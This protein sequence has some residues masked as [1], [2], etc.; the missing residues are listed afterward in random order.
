VSR[1][2]AWALPPGF[3]SPEA[4]DTRIGT[5]A[6]SPEGGHDVLLARFSETS[7]SMLLDRLGQGGDLLAR[8]SVREIAMILGRVGARFLDP[9]DEL[10]REAEARLPGEAALGSTMARLVIEGMARD[11]SE[12]R[13]HRLLEEEFEDPEVLDGLRMSGTG[14]LLGATGGRLAYHLGAGNVPGVGTTSLVRSLLVK[15]PVVLKPGQ[16][17]MTLP[18]L[19]ARGLAEVDPQ[20]AEALAVVYWPR[21]HPDA[22][23]RQLV[24][25][26]DRVVAYGGSRMVAELRGRIPATT[27]LVAYHHRVSVG[28]V[29]REA[30]ANAPEARRIAAAAARAVTLFEGRGCVSPR[31]IWVESGGRI[32]P[33]EWATMLADSLVALADEWPAPTPHPSE[34]AGIRQIREAAEMRIA[35]GAPGKLIGDPGLA[36]TVL[37]E[38]AERRLEVSPGR[39]VQLHPIGSLEELPARLEPLASVLQTVALEAPGPR[40][41]AL[42]EALRR[43]GVSR[44]TTFG[45]QPWPPAWW[46]HDGSGPLRSLV[47]WTEVE[48]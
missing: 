16:G 40:K 39:M 48:P 24:A 4:F 35:T 46:L 33:E 21:A 32:A 9:R 6:D 36:W 47:R 14:R 12:D 23:E 22:L 3:E 37:V 5:G 44:V 41:R 42:A 8:R 13:L 10:R 20:V 28:A 43:S 27:P 1:F 30:L 45:S 38:P 15:C 2:E 19:F 26:A 25:R 17:D 7:A 11:W 31:M 34:S 29:S 18:I